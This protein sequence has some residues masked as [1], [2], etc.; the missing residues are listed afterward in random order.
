M[1]GRLQMPKIH[2]IELRPDAVRR[3]WGILSWLETGKPSGDY[4]ACAVLD[5]KAG[6]SIGPHQGTDRSGTADAILI[7]TLDYI[8][9]TDEALSR[10]IEDLL[11][12]LA[13]N[14]TTTLN[15]KTDVAW[16]S[17]AVAGRTLI[18][19]LGSLDVYRRA[20]DDTF[21]ER[22]WEPALRAATRAGLKTDI[23]VTLMYD[24]AIQSGPGCIDFM[25]NQFK[26]KAPA[27]GGDERAWVRAWI[28]ARRRWL[29]SLDGD[30]KKTGYRMD[31]MQSL[32]DQD[33][34]MFDAP[35]K[36]ARGSSTVYIP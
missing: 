11:D 10:R 29:Q 31:V 7:R 1:A 20:C 15:P 5:D 22:Y 34:W 27:L 25:R 30:A 28:P 2:P 23:G 36:F 17:W 8:G 14:E 16:P 21:A 9:D 32:V 33:V 18:R 19:Y 13:A 26:A 6:F 12:H 24:T 35:F 4:G 3:S